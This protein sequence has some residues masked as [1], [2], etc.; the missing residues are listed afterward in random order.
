MRLSWVFKVLLLVL[1]MSMAISAQAA[2]QLPDTGQT[3]CYDA[4]GNVFDPCPQPGEPFYGQDAQYQGARSYTKLDV[5]GNDL[6]DTAAAWA[7]VRDNVTGLIWEVKTDD[8]TIHDKDNTYTW[9]DSNPATNGGNAG[10]PGNGTD[11]E[12]FIA[13][14]NAAN[15]GGYNDWR[16]PTVKE[17]ATL[18]HSGR[19]SP[20][21][22]TD[23]FP[24]SV[25][26][27]YWS[28]TTRVDYT[29][30]AWRV[31]FSHGYVSYGSYKSYSYY[32]RAVRSGP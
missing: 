32:V 15:F 6:P 28:S 9:Y 14:L 29:G 17:L 19:Y 8:G 20:A 25:S 3:Q 2:G 10:T 30:D 1:F 23:F 18:V 22:D 24:E 5:G 16:L 13:A 27:N 7:M 26:S 21:I 4:N 12:D 31:N 11:T